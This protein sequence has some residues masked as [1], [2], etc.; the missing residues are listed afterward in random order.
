MLISIILT[1]CVKKRDLSKN[2]VIAHILSQPDGL[3]PYNDNSVMRSFI[4]E[5]TQKT[6]TKLDLESLEYTPILTKNLAEI[7]EDGLRYTYEIREGITWDDGTPFTAEDVVFSTKIMLCP[8]TNNAQIRSN[9]S[10][11]IKSVEIDKNNPLKFTMVA[12]GINYT[13]KDIFAGICMQQKSYWDPN[14]ILDEIS[15]EDILL[16][17]FKEKI[18]TEELAEWFNKY[19]HADNGYDPKSK[20]LGP[21][22]VVDWVTS[23]YISI[24]KRKIGGEAT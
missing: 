17:D 24:E 19:N 15:F 2:T 10:T 4:F 7:S 13:N 9:Y 22:Q 8:L 16:E 5:Y 14:G 1:S 6:L 21:Y 3:H 23:Q 20:G 18:E 11:V 12:Q